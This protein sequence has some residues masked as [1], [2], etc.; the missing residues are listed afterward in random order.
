MLF[1][2]SQVGVQNCVLKCLIF[3]NIIKIWDTYSNS[4]NRFL[5]TAE[6]PSHEA[7]LDSTSLVTVSISLPEI[8]QP[9]LGDGINKYTK[10]LILHANSSNSSD[11]GRS[12]VRVS[13]YLYKI[14]CDRWLD[15]IT[16]RCTCTQ[17]NGDANRPL[18]QSFHF[19]LSMINSWPIF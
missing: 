2:L 9:L 10:I 5:G 18:Q 17:L 7:P 16:N 3:F 8:V 6:S 1:A 12:R 4:F 15:E 19:K 13:I 14:Y 11:H